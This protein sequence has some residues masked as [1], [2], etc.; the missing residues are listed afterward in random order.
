MNPGRR[1]LCT[2]ENLYELYGLVCSLKGVGYEVTMAVSY[3]RAKKLV[4]EA[5]FDAIVVSAANSSPDYSIP[6]SLK[7]LCPHTPILLLTLRKLEPDCFPDGV[8]AAAPARP[9]AVPGALDRLF[10]A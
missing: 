8:D 9:D 10:S 7:C 2:S 3:D 1:I 6:S 4:T 5:Q